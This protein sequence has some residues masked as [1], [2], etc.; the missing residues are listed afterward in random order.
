MLLLEVAQVSGSQ[1][2]PLIAAEIRGRTKEVSATDPKT[3]RH[4]KKLMEFLLSL[5]GNEPD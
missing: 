3:S 5:R 2:C 4:H 1:D